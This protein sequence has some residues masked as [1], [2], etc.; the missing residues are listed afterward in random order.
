MRTLRLAT[1]LLLLVA[2]GSLSCAGGTS[3]GSG[4]GVGGASSTRGGAGT[5]GGA[6]ADGGATANGGAGGG[7]SIPVGTGGE[8]T[9]SGC[10]TTTTAPLPYCGDSKINQDFEQC[11]DGNNN[12]GDG[13]GI[14]CEL[15]SGWVCS[16]PG[17]PCV[18]TVVCNDGKVGV[19]ESC[20]DRNTTDGDGCSSTCQVETGYTCPVPGEL[21]RPICGDGAVYGNEQCDTGD[22]NGTGGC[23]ATCKLE[24]GWVCPQ[25]STCRETVCGDGTKEGLEECDDGN[26]RPYD[27]CS[28][29]CTLEPVCGTDTSPVGKCT[30]KCGDGILLASAGEEC[31][32]ANTKSGDGCSSE[33]KLE[34]GYE[35]NKAPTPATVKIPIVYRD[36]KAFASWEGPGN[37]NPI[38]HPDFERTSP[39]YTD[40][41]PIASQPGIVT[42][43]LGLDRKPIYNGT[44]TVPP[45][46][47]SA[48]TTGKL[49]FDQWYRDDVGNDASGAAINMRIDDYLTLK[50]IGTTGANYSMDSRLD[51]PWNGLGGFFPLDG[52][53][54]GNEGSGSGGS[55]NFRFTSELRLWFEYKGNEKLEFSGDDDVW[56]FVDGTLAVDLGGIHCRQYGVVQLDTAGHGRSCVATANCSTATTT[57]TLAGDTDFAMVPGNIYEAVVFQ[58][59]RHIVDSNY[60]LTLNNFLTG[61]TECNSICGDGIVTPDEACDLGKALNTGGCGGCNPDC[62]L[63]PY[64]GNGVTDAACGEECDDGVN[65]SLYGGCAPGC[66]KGP[67]CGDGIVQAAFEQCDDGVNSGGYDK[68]GTGCV[69]GPRCGDG[70]LQKPPEQCDEGVEN[71]KGSCDKACHLDVIK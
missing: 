34:A 40:G 69:N 56:V 4:G 18:N 43:Q 71:G 33:C 1:A 17:L 68:C 58:A 29:T 39:T 37:T 57:C 16:T 63:A 30:S 9:G 5:N 7:I 15:E 22:S 42:A 2:T 66:V 47:T 55:H 70:I 24:P 44:D 27:G 64:C 45:G 14:H 20:D 49:Y 21:C 60:W 36:F 46:G 62:T 51:A 11:D 53:G 50:R 65:A 6:A 61:K 8:C 28:P 19:G 25:G 12:A 41:F 13:C 3:T 67:Y 54:F 10:A 38:G 35:C 52:K 23:S 59:E 32:D 48:E 31:D 26:T